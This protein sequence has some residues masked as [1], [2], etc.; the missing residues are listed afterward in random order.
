[1]DRAESSSNRTH[2]YTGSMNYELPFGK[3][4]K[5]LNHG[6][7]IN[8]IF[9]GFDMV[10]LYRIQSGDALTFGFGGSPYQYMPGVVAT[11]SGRP[12]STGNRAI[13]RDN[14]QDIGGD[15]F[16]QANQNGLIQ[17]MN[18]FSYP[19][20]YGLGNVGRNTFDRQRFIDCQFSASK[21]WR[22]KERATATFRFDFQNPF[23]WYN[24]S[25]PNTTVNFTNPATF[26]KVSTSTSDE[27]TT[28][29]AGGQGLMNIT[30]SFR[31]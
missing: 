13:L 27:G 18:Y 14:W 10:Y 23:K 6:G 15:R 4:R 8:A 29:N 20:A 31:F 19:D 17:S 5:W 28:A 16:V 9:G 24:L 30:L 26:G 3:G 25:A 22:I 1:M 21:E 11:R 2:M 12:N 7:F